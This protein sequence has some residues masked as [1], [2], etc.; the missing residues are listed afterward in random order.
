M[1]ISGNIA[2]F[3]PNGKSRRVLQVNN[4]GQLPGEGIA[5]HVPVTG[6]VHFR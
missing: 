5:A 6:S 3:V 4:L 2:G 1:L